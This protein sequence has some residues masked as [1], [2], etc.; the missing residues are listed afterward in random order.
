MAR[1]NDGVDTAAAEPQALLPRIE[2]LVLRQVRRAGDRQAADILRRRF[3]RMVLRIVR[4]TL[5]PRRD[6]EQLA[7]QI[8][9][10]AVAEARTPREPSSTATCAKSLVLAAT[11]SICQKEAR[12]PLARTR[13]E[14]D[15][16]LDDLSVIEA[17][18]GAAP[19]TRPELL[20]DLIEVLEATAGIPPTAGPNEN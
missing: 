1:I 10:R 20:L 6:L 15:D 4:L 16:A 19:D 9:S 2:D 8:F 18:R 7:S 11:I 13:A 14:S 3:G 17:L 5:G 12:E